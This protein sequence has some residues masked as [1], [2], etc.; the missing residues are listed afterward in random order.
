MLTKAALASLLSLAL[1]A[2]AA[3]SARADEPATKGDSATRIE[4]LE[5]EVAQLKKTIAELEKRLAK[6]EKGG[7]L[8]DM[9]PT[10]NFDEAIVQLDISDAEKEAVRDAVKKCKKAQL[11]TLD[12]PTK[13]KR[14]MSE[15][16]IDAF[17]K[18]QD[19]AEKAQAELQKIFI[20]L[21]T[22]KVPGDEKGRTYVQ[23]IEDHKKVMR[24]AIQKI[25]SPAD[26]QRLTAIHADWAEFELGEDDPWTEL[27]VSR[28]TKKK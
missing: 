24:T 6:L 4:E 7:G 18:A 28:M 25:L 20:F 27:Y 1:L 17:I 10:K 3:P 13:D 21:S 19:D 22:E 11:E 14:I 26:Q 2:C 9:K 23:V 5:K 8:A 12:V 16:L 15:E